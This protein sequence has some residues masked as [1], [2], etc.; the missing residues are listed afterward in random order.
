MTTYAR[1]LLESVARHREDLQA[2]VEAVA[3][4]VVDPEQGVDWLTETYIPTWLRLGGVEVPVSR[5]ESDLE[6]IAGLPVQPQYTLG[7][8]ALCWQTESG[9]DAI[10]T[11]LGGHPLLGPLSLAAWRAVDVGSRGPDPEARE[12]AI[13]G[14]QESAVTLLE[15]AA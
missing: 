8:L 4:G 9:L 5:S 12:A 13:A 10:R 2:R 3:G 7:I 15:R 1:A 11:L 6:R 14:L